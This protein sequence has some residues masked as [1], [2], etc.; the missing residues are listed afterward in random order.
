MQKIRYKFKLFTMRGEWSTRRWII[1]VLND[2]FFLS[3]LVS[4]GKKIQMPF[5]TVLVTFFLLVCALLIILGSEDLNTISELKVKI[6]ILRV[7]MS[8]IN[9]NFIIYLNLNWF[10]LTN[11]TQP[12][13]SNQ[14]RI[15]FNSLRIEF[16]CNL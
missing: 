5:G 14:K 16:S 4:V 10:R 9:T 3:F 11:F 8:L 6:T 13:V 12:I 15:Y 1:W 7:K 2:S